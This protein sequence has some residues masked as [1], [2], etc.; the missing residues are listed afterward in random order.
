[1]SPDPS[2]LYAIALM[3]DIAHLI[4]HNEIDTAK[5]YVRETLTPALDRLLYEVGPEPARAWLEAHVPV[6]LDASAFE[7]KKAEIIT[8][9]VKDGISASL[10]AVVSP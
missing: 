4:D 7:A 6:R 1:M 9:V 8:E 2:L 5:R 3:R 10:R